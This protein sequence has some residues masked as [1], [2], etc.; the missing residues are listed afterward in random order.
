MS[1][2]G[3]LNPNFRTSA[4][5][6][7]SDESNYF[8]GNNST[9]GFKGNAGASEPKHSFQLNQRLVQGLS[10]GSLNLTSL[11]LDKV[12]DQINVNVNGG[13]TAWLTHYQDST[14]SNQQG[15]WV[16]DLRS[17]ECYNEETMEVLDCSDNGG[18]QHVDEGVI[19]S[20]SN[21][22]KLRFKRCGISSFPFHSL[23]SP[24][25][26]IL[27]LSFNALKGQLR[28]DGWGETLTALYLQ[29]NHVT[30]LTVAS[31][32]ANL[33]DLDVSSNAL[34][35]LEGLDINCGNLM[36]VNLSRNRGLSSLPNVGAK[37]RELDASS[38][39][40]I[41]SVALE[42]C[43][44]LTNLNLASNN[45]TKVEGLN[46]GIVMLDIS[47]NSLRDVDGMWN[48]GGI[49]GGLGITEFRAADN[50]L[51]S[52]S[53]STFLPYALNLTLFDVSNNSLN[54][55]PS[56]LGYLPELKIIKVNGNELRGPYRVTGGGNENARV[57]KKKLR[58][59]S[60]PPTTT[61][62]KISSM[63][64]DRDGGE[65]EEGRMRVEEDKR[66]AR[67]GVSQGIL[68]L[69]YKEP[70]HHHKRNN[71]GSRKGPDIEG[72]VASIG[73]TVTDYENDCSY[74]LGDMVHTLVMRG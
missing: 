6:N 65:R 53:P 31:G 24:N 39:G 14:P 67:E 32:M 52:I 11:G 35:S 57:I 16:K 55:L 71:T 58:F 12:P 68:D 17:W 45:V 72:V 30:C 19:E 9:S 15:G 40:V 28:I 10:S 7:R 44:F 74:V 26:L 64:L 54:A 49:E 61:S 37:V 60:P 50:E 62:P 59:L 8:N 29:G 5:G 36:K 46:G 69:S 2:L 1:K 34:T 21:V 56:T 73:V 63:Y 43:P 4:Q 41:G 22:K 13:I 66:A 51:T 23:S 27:D 38:C 33:N 42:N 25:L 3:P 20:F 18:L 70:S 48:V 47:D